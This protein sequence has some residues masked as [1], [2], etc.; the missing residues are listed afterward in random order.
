[1]MSRT[2]LAPLFGVLQEPR[3]TRLVLL[4]AFADTQDLTIPLGVHGDCASTSPAQLRFITI[5]SG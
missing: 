5:P 1:M 2:P 4:R 3:S